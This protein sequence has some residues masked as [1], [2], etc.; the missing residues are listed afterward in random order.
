VTVRY[1]DIDLSASHII[2]TGPGTLD[3]STGNVD[4]DP[5]FVDPASADLSGFALRA[6][7]PLIGQGNPVA[8]GPTESTTDLAGNPRVVGGRRDIGAFEYQ[9]RAPVVVAKATPADALVGQTI[10]FDGSG[11][12]DPDPGDTLS[13]A[14]DFGDG[15]TAAGATAAHA[16]TGVGTHTVTLTVTDS[17]GLTAAATTGVTVSNPPPPPPPPPPKAAVTKLSLSPTSFRTATKGSS[18]ARSR[19]GTTVSYSL[20]DDGKTTF[21]VRKVLPGRRS[22]K[23]CVKPTAKLRKAKPC[24]RR[25]TVA[26]SFTHAGRKGANKFRFTGRIRSRRLAPGTY[27]LLASAGKNTRVVRFRIVLR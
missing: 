23:R 12:S 18:I 10:A 20:S 4:V 16:F 6:A 11:S 13:Y 22:G 9:A 8:P 17:A 27:E 14:W 5:L 19:I 21:R 26:G 1:S 7:S 15:T 2:S 3:T 25:T 24:T